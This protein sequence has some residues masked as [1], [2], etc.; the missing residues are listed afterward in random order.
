MARI[1]VIED[2]SLVREVV[3]HALIEAGHDAA[4][5]PDGPSG[6]TSAKEARPAAVVLD[7]KLPGMDGKQVLRALKELYADLP[8]FLFTVYGDFHHKLDVPEADGCFVKSAD[9]TPLIQAV[10][11]AVCRR[12]RGPR[13]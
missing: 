2:D 3:R 5:M 10:G 7:L 13:L 8:V 11:R 12:N 6:I 9:L 1:L 4:T